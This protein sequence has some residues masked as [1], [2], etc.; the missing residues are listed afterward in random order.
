MDGRLVL[1]ETGMVLLIDAGNSRVKFGWLQ[2]ESGR[3]EPR[4][5][6]L[7]HAELDGL[8]SWLAALP[9]KPSFAVGVNVAGDAIAAIV[10]AMLAAAAVH[11]TWLSGSREAAGITNLYDTPTQ[12][13]ADRWISLIGLASHTGESAILASFGTATTVDMLS[14]V[15]QGT[16][17]RFEGGII[18]PGPELMRRA[19]AS[20]TAGLPYAEGGVNPFP[21]HTHAAISSGIAAAQAGAV[22]GQW[23]HAVEV[24]GAAPE[25]YCTGGGWQ[26]VAETVTAALTRGQTDLQLPVNSPRWL[27]TPVLD[28]LAVMAREI[29]SGA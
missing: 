7:A 18:L 20:G 8:A 10:E 2:L 19:L 12:L 17:R 4:P 13:G 5:L 6:A 26:L 15:P 1:N 29:Y 23:R 24:W 9:C 22:L 14:A 16:A 28:G 27:E 25:V 3:R 11:C 21:R